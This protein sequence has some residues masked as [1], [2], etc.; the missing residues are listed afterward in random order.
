[1][2]ENSEYDHSVNTFDG[3]GR[4][5]QVEYALKAVKDGGTTLGIQL[6]DGII[7]AA[8]KKIENKLQIP[9]SI[10]KI[11]K[12]SDSI[13]CTFSGLLAD[14]RSLLDHSRVE[15]ANHWFVYNEQI[16][17]ETLA[18]SICELALS[19]A[20][21]KKKNDKKKDEKKYLSRPF[22]CSLLLGGIDKNGK[23][24]LYRNDPSGNYSKFKACCVGAG[25]ENGM[26]TL[27][28]NYNESMDLKEGLKLAAKVI[29]ENMEQKINKENIEISYITNKE[30]RIVKLSVDEIEDLIKEI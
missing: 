8:E 23:A 13:F 18:L 1:M 29:K 20:D 25:E 28:E 12:I 3:Q 6:K 27:T 11:F 24:V 17:I 10:E 15:T 5:I 21:D 16:P 19:F 30:K 9:S 7:L 14:G 26:T 22:G 4:L 2:F